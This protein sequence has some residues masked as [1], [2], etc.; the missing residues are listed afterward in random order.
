MLIIY[1][2]SRLTWVSFLK[3][4]SEAFEKF[5]VFKALSKNQTEKR[6]KE[7]RS[8][9]G[10]EFS[11]WNFKE[12][13]DKHGIKREYTIPRTPQQNGVVERHNRS[14]QQMARSMMNER[15]IPQTYWVEA[16]HTLFISLT[17]LISGHTVTRLL[18]NYG[19]EELLQSS[20]LKSLG[21][22][23]ISRTMM[24]ILA[25]MMTRLMKVSSWAMLQ[26]VKGTDVT[27]RGCIN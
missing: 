8:D 25:N 17:K 13:C 4:K 22:N 19:L 20:I 3:E 5:K 26:I 10:G 7:V 21:V 6:L 11:S 23:V 9:R 24:K 15:N 27:I 2:Y 16:I 12:Y 18:M 1:D 14:I